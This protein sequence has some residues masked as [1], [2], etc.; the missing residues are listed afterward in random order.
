ME[1]LT[2]I[3]LYLGLVY[4][5]FLITYLVIKTAI[6]HAIREISDYIQKII[7]DAIRQSISKDNFKQLD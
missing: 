7:T 1:A 6:K 5:F 3:I 4:I 2:F